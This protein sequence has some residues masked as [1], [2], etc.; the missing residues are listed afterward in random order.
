MSIT[1]TNYISS[2]D[3]EVWMEQKTEDLYGNLRGAMDTSNDRAEAE[4]ALNKIRADLVDAGK[5]GADPTA[6]RDEMQVTVDKYKDEFPEVA[7]ALQP[8]LDI[9]NTQIHDAETPPRTWAP[10]AGPPR[11]WSPVGAP[12]PPPP[13]PP[14]PAKISTEDAKDWGD[15]IGSA[16]DSLGKADQLGMINIQEFNSQINQTKQIAS[17]LLDSLDKSANAIIGHIS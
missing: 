2:S 13:P 7:D 1:A 15:A 14:P 11:N 3:L 8:K 10:Q 17:A 12:P 4:K 9:L 6:I 16:I 5:T